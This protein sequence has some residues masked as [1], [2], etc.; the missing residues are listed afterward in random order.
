MSDPTSDAGATAESERVVRA[1]RFEL[2]D[3]DGVVRGVVGSLAPDAEDGFWPGVSLRDDRGRERVWVIVEPDGVSLSFDLGG[4]T[5]AQLGVADPG[6]EA[7]MPGPRLI[8]CDPE[9]RVRMGW[10]VHLGGEVERLGS[11]SR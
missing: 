2:V 8:L 4:N 7:V 10:Q 11:R 1:G 5:V 6:P 3:G 9:G